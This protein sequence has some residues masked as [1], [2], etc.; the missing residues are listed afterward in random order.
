MSEPSE[1]TIQVKDSDRD[2]ANS[3]DQSEEGQVGGAEAHQEDTQQSR[4]SKIT[5]TLKEK[6]R[7]MQVAKII[8]L[9]Q[10]F[11]YIYDKWRTHVKSSKRTLSQSTETLPDDLLNDLI[12]DVLGFFADVQR[13]Y[14]EL[15]KITTPDQD[16]RCRV[17]L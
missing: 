8:S 5:R 17:D 4:R 14:D 6:G 16:T 9:Q 1:P 11:N 12:G 13:V 7:E 2:S 3:Q 10:R 15:R